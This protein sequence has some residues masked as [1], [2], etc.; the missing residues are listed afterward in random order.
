M[1]RTFRSLASSSIPYVQQQQQQDRTAAIRTDEKRISARHSEKDPTRLDSTRQDEDSTSKRHDQ[2]NTT[3]RGRKKKRPRSRPRPRPTTQHGTANQRHAPRFLAK[4]RRA[5]SWR[6]RTCDGRAGR[7]V[8]FLGGKGRSRHFLDGKGRF[9]SLLGMG[10][11]RK[12]QLQPATRHTRN[13]VACGWRWDGMGQKARNHERSHGTFHAQFNRA[14]GFRS[15]C[16]S[17]CLGDDKTGYVR[18]YMSPYILQSGS[19]DH[20]A[21][22]G[23]VTVLEYNHNIL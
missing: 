17:C 8:H 9:T 11:R 20:C 18:T 12:T 10:K 2:N 19:I 22:Q 3:R 21:T 5:T 4:M 1:N 13:G 15:C 6:R 23:G 7:I 14:W 16:V